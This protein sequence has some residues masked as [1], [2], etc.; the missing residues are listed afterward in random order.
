MTGAE[1]IA[2]LVKNNN[3]LKW[4]F[5]LTGFI[6]VSCGIA[7]L[8]S[9]LTTITSRIPL[10][11]SVVGGVVSLVAF[12]VGLV[13]SFIV[14]AIAWFRFRPIISIILL[15]GAGVAICLVK[16]LPKKKEN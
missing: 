16:F 11:G 12:T 9:F 7:S 14:C 10:L 15:V 6:L 3:M 1:I 8:F 2:A 4:I 13:I 5:R